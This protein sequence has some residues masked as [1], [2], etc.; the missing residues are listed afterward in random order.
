MGF[1]RP[2]LKTFIVHGESDASAAL[3]EKIKARLGWKVVIPKLNERFEL[4]S[5]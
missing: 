1:N 3:A 4:E 5:R 2:P